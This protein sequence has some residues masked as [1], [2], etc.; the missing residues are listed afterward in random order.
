MVLRDTD[1]ER[2]LEELGL[3]HMAQIFKAT[4]RS[5]QH[6]SWSYKQYP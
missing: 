3:T 4:L 1:L 6:E 5:C 2:L